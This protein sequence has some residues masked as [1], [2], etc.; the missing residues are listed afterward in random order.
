MAVS[1]I[2]ALFTFAFHLCGR[3]SDAEELVRDT[4]FHASHSYSSSDRQMPCTNWLFALMHSTWL[5]SL[6]RTNNRCMESEFEEIES[7]CE[8]AHTEMEAAIST[9]DMDRLA[10]VIDDRLTGALKRLPAHFRAVL[11]LS[12]VEGF[13]YAEIAEI[14]GAPIGTVMSRMYR[15]RRMLRQDL[16]QHAKALGFVKDRKHGL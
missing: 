12:S 7:V 11:L 2:D 8:A 1:H 15:A 9:F 14:T 10:Q 13:S 6:R 3:S 4:L 5:R 16:W